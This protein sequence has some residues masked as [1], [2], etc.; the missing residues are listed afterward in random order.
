MHR[1]LGLCLAVV[2]ATSMA[3]CDGSSSKPVP[4][5]PQPVINSN[6]ELKQR[7]N[8]MAESGVTGSALGGLQEGIKK[9]GKE[10]LDKDLAE[11][12]KAHDP[13]TVKQI[14]KR[15]AEKL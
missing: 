6:E 5:N 14:A 4:S 2:L 13:A 3:G 9:L 10:D 15:M 12:E 7:L 8:Y 11:L 1:L